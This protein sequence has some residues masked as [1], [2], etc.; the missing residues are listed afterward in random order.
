MFL[1]SV[2]WNIWNPGHYLPRSHNV[3]LAHDSRTEIESHDE[4]DTRPLLVKA[5]TALGSTSTFGIFFRKKKKHRLSEELQDYPVSD[6][7]GRSWLDD[8]YQ[9]IKEPD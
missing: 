4:S 5:G 6:R 9:S 7:E 3:Y 1:N 2:L 8:L